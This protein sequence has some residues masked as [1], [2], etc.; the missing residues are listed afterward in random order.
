MESPIE[1][2]K[3]LSEITN[4]GKIA[5]DVLFEKYIIQNKL[6][7]DKVQNIEDTDQ[8]SLLRKLNGGYPIIGL[9]YTFIYKPSPEELNVVMSGKK[10]EKY[11]DHVPLVF[12]TSVQGKT[13][14]GI[15]LNVLPLGERLKFLQLY[16]DTFKDFFKGLEVKTQN[17]ILAINNK[18]L[19]LA[20]DSKGTDLIK[21]WSDKANATFSFGYRKYKI[22]KID[23]LRAIEFVEW[24]YIPFFK[25][26]NATKLMNV[27]KIHNLYWKT[28]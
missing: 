8:E 3:Y 18:F 1:I 14:T 9:I 13:F 6:G 4:I 28:S 10:I 17:N 19:S 21:M 7:Y 12:C 2:Y 26:E 16:Y 23:R 20:L 25:S 5:N 27:S 24:S 11:T 15:N 22:E